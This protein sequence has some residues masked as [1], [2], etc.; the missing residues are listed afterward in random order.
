MSVQ[1]DQQDVSHHVTVLNRKLDEILDPLRGTLDASNKVN[2]L[3]DIVRWV[4]QNTSTPQPGG[5]VTIFPVEDQFLE[6]HSRTITL[7]TSPVVRVGRVAE[8]VCASP[9]AKKAL[10]NGATSTDVEIIPKVTT[11]QGPP[12]ILSQAVLSA[13]SLD[14]D[15]PRSSVLSLDVDQPR[16][17]FNSWMLTNP[18]HLSRH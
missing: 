15:Q 7:T 13:S 6:I 10:F 5:S 11:L 4:S 9:P 8:T 14:I 18:V 17:A 3:S 2:N 1:T 16:S 12:K